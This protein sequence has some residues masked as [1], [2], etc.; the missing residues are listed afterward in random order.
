MNA[1]CRKLRQRAA[2]DGV[3][4][5][6]D[7]PAAA[8]HLATCDGCRRA[9]EALDAVDAAL[10]D[11]TPHD[12]PESVVEDLL[13]RVAATP[14]SVSDLSPSRGSMAESDSILGRVLAMPRRKPWLRTLVATAAVA[15]IALSLGLFVRRNETSSVLVSDGLA[16]VN[17]PIEQMKLEE[18]T[19]VDEATIENL[20]ALGY[21]SDASGEE[22]DDFAPPEPGSEAFKKKERQVREQLQRLP[23][24]V[25]PQ[26]PSAPDL[27][28]HSPPASALP[29]SIDRKSVV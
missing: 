17:A 8:E 22:R 6:R 29:Q 15:L 24:N 28:V 7:A 1:L 4:V 23:S 2:E 13:A 10:G 25:Q 9:L 16:T 21:V 26:P 20:K 3:E 18:S 12:A 11:L 19:A 5:V 14:D 27:S